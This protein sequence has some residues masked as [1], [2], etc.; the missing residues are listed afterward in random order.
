MVRLKNTG[1]VTPESN[2]DTLVLANPVEAEGQLQAEGQPQPAADTTT[3][4]ETTDTTAQTAAPSDNIKGEL[5]RYFKEVGAI[6]NE[7]GIG[8]KALLG[9][10]LKITEGAA[11]Q[12]IKPE[13][14]DDFYKKFRENSNK[15]AVVSDGTVIVE[16][17]NAGSLKA[18]V[19]KL[20]AFIKFGNGYSDGA[21]EIMDR[22]IVVHAGL[23]ANPADKKMLKLKS[24]YSAL[25]A[26]AREQLSNEKLKG[27]GMSEDELRQ[28]FLGEEQQAKIGAD[29]IVSAIKAIRQAKKGKDAK[30]D[31]GVLTE[32]RAPIGHAGLDRAI[33]ELRQVLADVAPA[34]YEA[35]AAADAKE[36]EKANAVASA[37]AIAEAQAEESET[38]QEEVAAE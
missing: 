15:K 12:I 4:E 2:D 30:E 1:E 14:A 18:Q 21:T 3:A 20:R 38:D 34:H 33:D 32:G 19:S 26:V 31:D 5:K 7:H 10:A 23:M 11:E 6:G 9:L 16:G 29:Y 37:E 28:F 27:V 8:K 13:H 36:T 25:V 35:L 22:A 17:E 24:T